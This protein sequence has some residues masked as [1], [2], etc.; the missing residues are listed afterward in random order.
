[1]RRCKM[2]V[3]HGFKTICLLLLLLCAQQLMAQAPVKTYT[4][5]NGKMFIAL[6]KD[7]PAV[8]L[9][10]FIKKYD[11]GDLDLQHFIKT[12]QPD[13]LHKLGWKVDI[14]NKEMVVISKPLFSADN[15]SD[16]ANKIIL[17]QK[18][19]ND[20][21]PIANQ[22]HFGV[23][24]FKNKWPFAVEDSV[25]T[26]FLKGHNN[27]TV[28]RVAGSFT[29]WQEGA[30]PMI[31][32]DSGWIAF[33]KLP[34]G[35][36][37]YKFI[38]DNNWTTDKENALTENDG[39]GNDNSVYFKT[40]YTFV[41]NG[42][43]K[44]KRVFL[45]GSFNNWKPNDLL[46]RPSASG[47][48]LPV[49]LSEGTHTYRFIADGKWFIDPANP[50]KVPNE[51]DDFNSV[52]RMGNPYVFKLDGYANAKKVELFGSF[53]NWRE[54]QL[55]MTK[56]AT[57]WQLPYT[58]GPGNYEYRLKIDGRLIADSIGNGNLALVIAPNFTFRLNGFDHAKTVCV[59]GDLN[60]WNA[61]SFQMKRLGNEWVF[62]AH[63]NKGKHTYKFVV[64]GK[65]ILDPG[66]KLWEQNEFSTGNSVLWID[67]D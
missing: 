62:P 33:V 47:W 65:W 64:D 61:S 5:K 28:V 58:L 21:L 36:H 56:T 7:I 45:A 16:P 57:G 37:F 24:W 10:S 44:S 9:D 52:V 42:Y 25:V 2:I 1:M 15:L 39:M 18:A 4:I 63:L 67:K 17:T 11:L 27:A 19:A 53:N 23:N 59:S 12:N 38:I 22:V 55:L 54:N 8:S 48:S 3:S 31:K 41:L 14:D 40:N 32:V 51:F 66:N 29:N 35:K 20:L 26:F 30:L 60:N 49:Y 6:G 13:S 46:M 50:D 43:T 34:T